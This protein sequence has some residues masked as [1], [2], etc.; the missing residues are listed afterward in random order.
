MNESIGLVLITI[1]VLTIKYGDGAVLVV[2]ASCLG[3]GLLFLIDARIKRLA[4][5][6]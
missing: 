4:G 1:A 6:P 2:G 5:K 3:S